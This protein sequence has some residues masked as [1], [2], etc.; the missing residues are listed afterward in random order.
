MNE[1][2]I[3]TAFDPNSGT[4]AGAAF[5]PVDIN[6][7]SQTRCDARNAYFDPY[8]SRPN[9]W[10]ATGQTVTQILLAGTSG[11]QNS[12]IAIAGDFSVGQG[13]TSAN[14][15]LFGINMTTSNMGVSGISAR[16]TWSSL[17]HSL[18]RSVI[19]PVKR[20][21]G[22]ERRQVTVTAQAPPQFRAIGVQVGL[23]SLLRPLQLTHD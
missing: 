2:G 18:L 15:S 19:R 22:A 11:N 4:T 1:L 8:T 16:W 3:P 20:W 17:A 23:P 6:P 13:N 9:L 10:V 21:I 5:L 7:Q 12:S 14:G